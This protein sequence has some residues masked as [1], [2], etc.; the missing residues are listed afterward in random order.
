VAKFVP[1]KVLS[2]QQDEVAIDGDV[3][4]GDKVVILPPANLTDGTSL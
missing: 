3:N 2:Q 4:S 1:V